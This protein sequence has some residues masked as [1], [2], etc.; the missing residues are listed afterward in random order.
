MQVKPLNNPIADFLP[1]SSVALSAYPVVYVDV[2]LHGRVSC[3]Q[4]VVLFIQLGTKQDP[5]QGDS[6][7]DP[8]LGR[9][10]LPVWVEVFVGEQVRRGCPLG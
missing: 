8:Y 10:L 9:H 5:I 3:F 7:D 1:T 6:R 4:I 2:T